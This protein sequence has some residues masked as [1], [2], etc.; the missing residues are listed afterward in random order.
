MNNAR[1]EKLIEQMTL[2]EKVGQLI[3]LSADFFGTGTEL[4]GPAQSWG[5]SADELAGI[6]SCIGG[7]DAT[8]IRKIQE[9]HLRSDRNKIPLVFM[10]DVIH[11]YRTIYPIGL[12]LSG[13]FD[14]ELVA[15]C[16]KMAAK[17]AAASGVHVT[18]APMVDLVR[19]PRWGRVMESC[20]E[21]P[22]L[23][24]V[25]AETQVKAYQ[26]EDV[27]AHN[28]LAACVK[29][30]AAYG[31]AES[32]RDYN[33]VEI[34]E[35]T[36]R[37]FYLPSYK[38]CVDAGVKMLMPSFN[39]LNGIPSTA[40]PFLMKQILREEWGFDGMVISDWAAIYELMV[41][42]VAENRRE[43]ARMAFENGCHM[44]M[45][46]NAYYKH[47]ASLVRD[48]VIAESAIDDAVRHVLRLKDALG[49]FDDPYH[50]GDDE[51]ANA[52]ALCDAHRAIVRRAAEESAVLLKN[53]NVLPF[54]EETKRIAI[55][56][57]FADEH[58]IHGPWSAMG[59]PE[60]TVSVYEGIAKLMPHAEIRVEKGCGSR[61][62][63]TDK[64]GFDAAIEAAGWADAVILALGEPSDYSGE[65]NCRTD[66]RLPGVQEDLARAV[67][68]ANANSVL[69]LFN[70][71][72]LVLKDI[73]D[74][75]PAILEM[76]F[77]GT[78]GGNAAAALLF[79]KVNPC[80]KLAM[81]FPASVGQCP[82][83]YNRTNT[84]RPKGTPDDQPKRFVSGYLDCGNLPLFFFGQGLSYT[85]FNYES[86]MLDKQEMT[87]SETLTVTVRVK[88]IG[89]RI[90]KEV[91]QLYLRDMVSSAVRPIQELI[92]FEKISLAPGESK[93]V[94]FA[95]K[96]SMLRFWNARNEYL[97]ET[98]DFTLSVG[99]ADHMVLSA[100][101]R[102]CKN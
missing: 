56:G 36:L 49:L 46:S 10:R 87:P 26:G 4:T 92:A 29:H 57:P 2:E 94:R 13:S 19:D 83:Y 1:L 33:A 43:A 20:G 96:E 86:I 66:L 8:A 18:F 27:S 71:R 21:D 37:Q 100:S 5:L 47:L 63:D 74:V 24:S 40:N 44:E 35:R 42:G 39:D 84:G 59:R 89:T 45:V 72:P 55:I 22:H 88:N 6:G 15:E 99:Y 68:T 98:G 82:I 101:F 79:G 54:S 28:R 64:S 25:M 73:C 65:G 53:D 16:T 50:G 77:P 52:L 14:P 17:E 31:G 76:W 23:A 95:V 51:L 70:G 85:T 62:T 34:S 48:G 11:G 12:G 97:S 81:T 75:M 80:G 102:L 30:F 32:G 9:E 69:L 38:A 61:I 60:E 93:D 78:E 91:V 41:H 90:G 7:K 67:A 3:Q 58:A